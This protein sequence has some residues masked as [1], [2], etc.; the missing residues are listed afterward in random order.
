MLTQKE[1]REIAVTLASK[2]CV[3]LPNVFNALGD[4][5]RYKVFILFMERE[6]LCVSDV[7]NILGVSVPAASQQLRIMEK[8]GLVERVRDGQKICYCLKKK[9]QYVVQLMKMVK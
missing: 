9:N 8:G 3:T 2:D 7:A 5:G 1:A 4:S 6:G